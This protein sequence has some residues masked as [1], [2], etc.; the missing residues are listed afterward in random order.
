MN[1]AFEQALKARLLWMQV[2]CYGSLGFHRMAGS[3]ARHAYWLVEELAMG[4]VRCELPYT[5]T[6]GARCPT[7]LNDIPRLADLYEQAWS[8]E[9]RI[10]E[11][12]RLSSAEQLLEEQSKVYARGCVDRNN[13]EAL[14]LPSPENLSAELYAGK[15]ARVK[16]HFLDYEDGIVWMDN[17]YGVEGALGEEPTVQL[18]RQ[19]LTRVAMGGMYGPEP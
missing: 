11:E 15:P 5:S 17:P 1:S 14:D 4:Q 7:V 13:W 6:Y 16:G 8:D 19:F 2:R 3:A 12:E 9:A 10:V 18:C